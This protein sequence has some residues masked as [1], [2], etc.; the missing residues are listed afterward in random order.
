MQSFTHILA[1]VTIARDWKPN[2][3]RPIV[4]KPAG[5]DEIE[6]LEGQG[7]GSVMAVFYVFMF[8]LR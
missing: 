8:W 2:C 3:Y 5:E 6:N 1:G 7:I 4:Q